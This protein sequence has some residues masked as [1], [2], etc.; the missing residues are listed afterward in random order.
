MSILDELI[1][2][3][4]ARNSWEGIVLRMARRRLATSARHSAKD[5]LAG[6]TM[7]STDIYY[8][9]GLLFALRERRT[10]EGAGDE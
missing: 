8:I 5:D 9:H 4:P 3:G 6:E 1:A 7:A 2:F 10:Y